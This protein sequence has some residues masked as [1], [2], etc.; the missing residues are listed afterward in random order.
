MKTSTK[1]SKLQG[2]SL[3]SVKET[4]NNEF[5]VI[6]TESPNKNINYIYYKMRKPQKHYVV[7]LPPDTDM[8]TL[9]TNLKKVKTTHKSGKT[10]NALIAAYILKLAK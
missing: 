1:I 3:E 7:S 4:L 9:R 5:T 10:A 2:L 8:V 6:R